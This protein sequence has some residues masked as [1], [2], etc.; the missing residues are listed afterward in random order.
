MNDSLL[1]ATTAHPD[2]ET[3]EHKKLMGMIRDLL[4]YGKRTEAVLGNNQR[5]KKFIK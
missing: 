3:D 1:H 5:S 4:N 2:S